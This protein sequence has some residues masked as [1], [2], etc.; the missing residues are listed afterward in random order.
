[1]SVGVRG[2]LVLAALVVIAAGIKAAQALMV[3]FLLS[4]FVATIASTPL[5]WLERNRVPKA[6]AIILVISALITVLLAVGALFTQSLGQFTES[7][8]AYQQRLEI[9]FG[10]LMDWV[11]DLGLPPPADL[12]EIFDPGTALQLAGTTLRGL[13]GVLS[14]GFLILLTVIFVLAEASTI[15]PKLVAALK[16]PG[17][18]LPHFEQF[19]TTLNRYMAIKAS[20]SV[21]TGVLLGGFLAIIG[22]D[23]PFLWGL[24]AFFL[25]FVPAIGSIIAAVPP[26]LLALMQGDGG[27]GLA[28]VTALGFLGT[29]ILIGNFIEPRFLGAGL[30]LSALVV[31][32]SI[33]FWGWMLGPVGMLLAVPLTVTVKIA[34]DASESTWRLGLLLGPARAASEVQGEQL[35]P[36]VSTSESN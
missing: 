32:L 20:T 25:N 4:V 22:V 35:E 34:L 3:P 2:I 14:N 33:I 15:R 19:A 12:T 9:L 1:M 5:L 31:L 30:G 13:G 29:N 6:L 8:P 26:V 23:Y 21:L 11:V 18:D 28:L 36:Q 17:R 24:L 16:N 27:L 10:S 7:L